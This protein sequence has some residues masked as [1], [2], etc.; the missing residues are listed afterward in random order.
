V[1]GKGRPAVNE[2]NIAT[3]VHTHGGNA[4]DLATLSPNVFLPDADHTVVL[5]HSIVFLDKA[6][7]V[8]LNVPINNLY[9]MNSFL[10]LDYLKALKDLSFMA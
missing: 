4:E 10:I 5:H 6:F 2:Q 9:L 3:P 7:P 8:L 1:D